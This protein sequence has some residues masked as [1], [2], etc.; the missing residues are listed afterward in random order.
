[1]NNA[2]HVFKKE[3]VTA[4]PALRFNPLFSN[5]FTQPDMERTLADFLFKY[6]RS[7]GGRSMSQNMALA[8]RLKLRKIALPGDKE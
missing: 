7:V 3:G 5:T 6:V 8:H 2:V 4:S 1:M